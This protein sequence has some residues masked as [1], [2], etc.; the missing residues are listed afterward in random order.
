[1][2]ASDFTRFALHHLYHS[3]YSGFGTA[4]LRERPIPLGYFGGVNSIFFIAASRLRALFA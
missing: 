3:V 2:I 1:M 4:A